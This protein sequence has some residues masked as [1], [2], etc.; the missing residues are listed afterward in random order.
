MCRGG[1]ARA[2]SPGF[3]P[4]LASYQPRDP[5]ARPIFL[6]SLGFPLGCCGAEVGAGLPA[7]PGGVWR[8]GQRSPGE[9]R[10]SRPNAAA[11]GSGGA[12]I[13]GGDRPP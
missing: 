6:P 5:R 3:Q 12:G 11:A 10:W 2:G 8:G 1:W 9:V 7:P 4:H 13:W